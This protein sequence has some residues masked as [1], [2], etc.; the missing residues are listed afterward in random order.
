MENLRQFFLGRY[1]CLRCLEIRSGRPLLVITPARA[2]R[3]D[4]R[5]GL[6]PQ[7]SGLLTSGGVCWWDPGKSSLG[8][9]VALDSRG[10]ISSHVK[11]TK[12]N[13]SLRLT[14][15]PD[16]TTA[17]HHVKI[18]GAAK[19]SL[20][21]GQSGKRWGETVAVRLWAAVSFQDVQV[22]LSFEKDVHWLGAKTPKQ[23]PWAQE[24]CLI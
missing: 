18:S 20:R 3:A 5:S 21:R 12:F 16:H 13:Y 17:S 24:N 4:S 9:L 22:R 15:S 19:A 2:T 14:S 8:S 7:T 6:Y 1:D 10:W 23:L 11:V